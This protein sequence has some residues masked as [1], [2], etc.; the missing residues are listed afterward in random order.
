MSSNCRLSILREFK[1]NKKKMTYR[2]HAIELQ[3]QPLFHKKTGS[4]F[5]EIEYCAFLKIF[6]QFVIFNRIAKNSGFQG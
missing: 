6:I 3:E 2:N 1:N 5:P 4:A